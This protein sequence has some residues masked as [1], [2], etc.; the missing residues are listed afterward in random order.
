MKRKRNPVLAGAALVAAAAVVAIAALSSAS[1]SA[2]AATTVKHGRALGKAVLVNRAGRT[3]Y[4]LSA[5]TNGRFICTGACLSTWHPLVVHRG[6]RPTGAPALSTIRRSTG[7]IQ[8]TYKGKPL[9]TFAGDRKPGDAKGEGFRDVGVWHA[10]ALRGSAGT[11]PAAPQPTS[12][13]PGYYGSGG[14]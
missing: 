9:Y 6:R 10:A 12:P 2:S 14:Y 3:L 11:T 4:S 7:Q 1:G 5:E 8:V 13:S